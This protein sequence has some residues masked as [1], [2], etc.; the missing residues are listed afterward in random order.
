[1]RA[2]MGIQMR[3]PERFQAFIDCLFRAI[4]VEGRHLG[5]PA[6]VA[7]VL[8]EA[9][10][11]PEEVLNL[12]NDEKVKAALKD[13]TEQAVQRGVFGAPSMFVGN[14]LFFGQDRLEFVREALR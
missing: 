14:D 4:W 9:G 2:V 10:F 8:S 11:D 1:M 3:Q 12:A 13:K 6:V 5:D 7:A